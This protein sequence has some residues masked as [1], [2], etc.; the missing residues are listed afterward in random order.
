MYLA[1]WVLERE[2]K[3]V[4]VPVYSCT[5]LRNEVP[6]AGGNSV[7]LDCSVNIP[8]VDIAHVVRP[9]IDILIAPSMFGI[10]VDLTSARSYKVIEDLAQSIGAAVDG[11]RIV[12]RGEVGICS[13]YASKL[14][15][16]G[17]QG[18]AVIRRDRTLIDKLRDFREFDC[19]HDA[20]FRFNFQMTDLQTAVGRV[21][22]KRLHG[23]I[24]LRGRWFSLYRQA[25]L[26]LI[27]E[28]TS[29]MQ[30]VRYC[31]V[32]RCD[33]P[34]RVIAAPASAGVR[35]TVQIEE[36][37]LLDTPEIYPAARAWANTTASLPAD[38][39]LR[40]EEAVRIARI[41]KEAA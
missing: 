36:Y 29:G 14:I 15:S 31:V 8:N 23:L 16:S 32:M 6:L 25:E 9:N 4:G 39:D 35:A 10:L 11:K 33:N 21:K 37:E 19:H 20:R 28:K 40:V 30:P 27:D 18:G 2:G 34:G 17:S 5:A 1:F 7:H 12:L 22:L 24:E 41:A 3:R 26:D 13:F 38:P